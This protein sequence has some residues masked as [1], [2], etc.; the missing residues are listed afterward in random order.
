MAL[1]TERLQSL[2]KRVCD[3][4]LLIRAEGN[5]FGIAGAAGSER[6]LCTRQKVDLLLK[7][8]PD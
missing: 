6:E 7:T 8:D 1:Q 3:L 2:G 4:P 5:T